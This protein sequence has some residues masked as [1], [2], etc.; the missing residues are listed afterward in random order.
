MLL[1]TGWR[2]EQPTD[3]NNVLRCCQAQGAYQTCQVR[4]KKQE[5]SRR[6][7]R[8]LPPAP[9]APSP[10]DAVHEPAATPS[11][12][13]SLVR[14]IAH[15]HHKTPS[16]EHFTMPGWS[17]SRCSDPTGD[18]SFDSTPSEPNDRCTTAHASQVRLK[19]ASEGPE[20]SER[21][22]TPRHLH[23]EGSRTCCCPRLISGM[24]NH[25]LFCFW[26]G[27]ML[28]TPTLRWLNPSYRSDPMLLSLRAL[29]WKHLLGCGLTN[30]LHYRHAAS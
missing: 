5:E 13:A 17:W 21:E 12:L 4:H 27:A 18:G 19:A 7:A 14:Y 3:A 28:L 29:R 1:S 20:K 23:F 26:K 8:G 30:E 24:A 2:L 16:V 25:S 6:I 10:D 9:T 11:W 15:F 22:V